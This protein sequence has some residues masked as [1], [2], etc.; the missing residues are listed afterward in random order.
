MKKPVLLQLTNNCLV[1]INNI[2]LL[3]KNEDGTVEVYSSDE[4]P[5]VTLSSDEYAVLLGLFEV[6]NLYD[7]THSEQTSFNFKERGQGGYED[8]PE[9][10]CPQKKE[11]V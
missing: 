5:I 7:E 9:D 3:I 11:Q 6:V 8:Y 10:L 4:F 1:P 2:D